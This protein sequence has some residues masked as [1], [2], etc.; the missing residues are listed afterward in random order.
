MALGLVLDLVVV[1]GSTA[2]LSLSVV[3]V[4]VFV[5]DHPNAV[6]LR[7]RRRCCNPIVERDRATILQDGVGRSRKQGARHK[8]HDQTSGHGHDV[9]S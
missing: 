1:A 2:A 6:C 8:D 5:M 7:P 4:S 3:S 9:W